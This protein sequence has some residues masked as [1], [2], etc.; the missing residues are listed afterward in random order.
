MKRFFIACLAMFM[1]VGFSGAAS[2]A[3]VLSFDLDTPDDFVL[4]PGESLT[5]DL[6]AV[7]LDDLDPL[8]ILYELQTFGFNLQYDASL[9]NITDGSIN[10]EW[11]FGTL[12]WDFT[13]DGLLVGVGA[14]FNFTPPPYGIASPM[15]LG[16]IT[17]EYE[18]PGQSALTIF[19][20]DN[21]GTYAD[22]ALA[23]DFAGQDLDD[24]IAD[25]LQIGG[26]NNVPIPAAVWLLGSGLIGLVG[27][28]RKV[29]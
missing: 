4:N 1:L 11:W 2:A 15:L 3:P 10:P 22:F 7:V 28:R 19:D 24:Q 20:T 16:N 27:L 6:Y 12:E 9:L 8:G 17:F 5:V 26:I 13:T 23:G 14:Y 18:A 25:G 21:G 29:R